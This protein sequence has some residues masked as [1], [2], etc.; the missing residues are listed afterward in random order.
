MLPLNFFHVQNDD[1]IHDAGPFSDKSCN[2]GFGEKIIIQQEEIN[3]S[4]KALSKL[5]P[6]IDQANQHIIEIINNFNS[7]K[8]ENETEIEEI[9]IT[10]IIQLWRF[11][12]IPEPLRK[13]FNLVLSTN[14][15]RSILCSRN[16]AV[17]LM[18]NGNYMCKY[19]S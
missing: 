7:H 4:K 5:Y 17:N 6:L 10:D 9:D 12:E 13:D 14:C 2:H 19:S 11:L 3:K 8:N 16:H 18:K 1:I 15:D